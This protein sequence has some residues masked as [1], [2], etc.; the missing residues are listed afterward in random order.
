ME[1]NVWTITSHEEHLTADVQRCGLQEILKPT[2]SR[3]DWRTH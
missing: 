3:A 1:T 2:T